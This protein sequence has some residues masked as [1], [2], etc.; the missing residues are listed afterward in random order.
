MG[1]AGGIGRWKEI[2]KGTKTQSGGIHSD[3]FVAQ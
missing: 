3:F 2:Q 1:R